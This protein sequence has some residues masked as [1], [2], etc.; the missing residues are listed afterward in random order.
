MQVRLS[1]LLDVDT[2]CDL[3][4]SMVLSECTFLGA[5]VRSGEQRGLV[6]GGGSV[7]RERGP[8]VPLPSFPLR[9]S[10]R[11]PRKASPD[12]APRSRGKWLVLPGTCFERV[13]VALSK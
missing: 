12:V 4:C 10:L 2:T 3:T 13:N 5:A 11:S 8:S 9:P 6:G 1:N 7:A